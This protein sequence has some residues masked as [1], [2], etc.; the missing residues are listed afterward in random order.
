[1][2]KITQNIDTSLTINLNNHPGLGA[3]RRLKLAMLVVRTAA[4]S[5][6]VAWDLET[7][8]NNLQ[9]IPRLTERLTQSATDSDIVILENNAV[10]QLIS[11]EAFNNR[12]LNGPEIVDEAGIPTGQFEPP[13]HPMPAQW[14][15]EYDF[16]W[17]T[18]CGNNPPQMHLLLHQAG[19][20]FAE[21]NGLL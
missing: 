15:T 16:W 4:R 5:I 11:L 3:A 9:P 14:A 2:E 10:Q 1:M 12:Y 20:Q 18:A 19:L 13:M 6:E 21:R 7:L 8:D 17:L